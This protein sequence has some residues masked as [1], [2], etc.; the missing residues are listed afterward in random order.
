MGNAP[1]CDATYFIDAAFGGA[2][3]TK[4]TRCGDDEYVVKACAMDTDTVCASC[5]ECAE[6]QWVSQVCKFD[7]GSRTLLPEQMRGHLPEMPTECSA[8]EECAVGAFCDNTCQHGDIHTMG[9]ATSCAGCEVALVICG[10][11]TPA[12]LT[13]REPLSALTALSAPTVSTSSIS[14]RTV[15][16]SLVKVANSSLTLS[17]RT[18]SVLVALR[19]VRVSGLSSHATL[20]TPVTLSTRSA[21]PARRES[22]SLL[23]ALS[24]LTPCA[25]RARIA[26]TLSSSAMKTS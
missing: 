2:K 16:H 11:Q 26:T 5:P 10:R 21:L 22:T 13:T 19:L 1:G 20:S 12:R 18:R 23:P 8:C 14:V 4:C 15:P 17:A 9:A 25:H 24:S 3:C 6:N 7:A